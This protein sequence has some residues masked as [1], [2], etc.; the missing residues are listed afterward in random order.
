MSMKNLALVGSCA[1][2]GSGE[3]ALMAPFFFL[4]LI[5]GIDFGR[6][7]FYYVTPSDLARNGAR[8]GAAYDTG[9]GPT[10][11]SITS[12]I[13]QQAKAMTF[14]DLTQPAACGTST[15]PSPL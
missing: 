2:Q 1:G 5:G 7:G 12:L 11:A 10:D 3:C 14:A 6:A 13:Q 15:P 4:I 9:T 8:I